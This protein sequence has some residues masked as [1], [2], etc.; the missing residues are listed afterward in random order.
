MS[1]AA[2]RYKSIEAG[3]SKHVLGREIFR[4]GAYIRHFR[5][6]MRSNPF[7]R[8]Y[9]KKRR[10]TLAIVSEL[11]GVNRILDVGGGPGRVSLPLATHAVACQVVLADIGLEV[12]K[13]VQSI[14]SHSHHLALINTDAH[15]LS[16]RSDLFDCVISLDLLCHLET[17]AIALREFHRVLRRKGSLII[18]NTNANP[19][20][21]LFYPRYLGCNPLTWLRIIR[22]RGVYPGWE[23]IVRHYSEKTFTAL[24]ENSGFE[25]IK[26]VNYGPTV[27]PK[28]HLRLCTKA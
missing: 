10:D 6:E 8:I 3:N 4:S 20:W 24:L 19:L 26:M 16:C 18:D 15:A 17:P 23:K 2:D 21:A 27:C 25:T 11:K 12:L 9:E 13:S 1:R 14:G 5:P 7:Q 22:F 28:W